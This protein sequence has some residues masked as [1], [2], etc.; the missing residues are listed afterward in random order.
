M[1]ASAR[2]SAA[3]ARAELATD[4]RDRA[5]WRAAARAWEQLAEGGRALSDRFPLTQTS[6]TT[7]LPPLPRPLH[8][9]RVTPSQYH[10]TGVQPERAGIEF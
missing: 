2:A 9:S 4:P 10:V 3:R 1:T 6:R 5:A 8:P 7:V